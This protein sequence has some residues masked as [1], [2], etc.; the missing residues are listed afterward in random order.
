MGRKENKAEGTD[1][2]WWLVV[3]LFIALGM[4]R[5]PADKAARAETTQIEQQQKAEKKVAV[6]KEKSDKAF[7]EA[8]DKERKTKEEVERKAQD[9][10]NFKLS[11]QTI[12][13]KTLARNPE[14]YKGAK[15]T[16]TGKVLQVLESG[17]D[18]AM[19]ITI[20]QNMDKV[21]Y[22][23]YRKDSVE[24]RILEDDMVTFY[25]EFK[26]IKQYEA[27]M[28]NKVSVPEVY[29]RYITRKN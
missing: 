20:E 1:D 18:I 22:V 27:I 2:L 13:Y 21:F 8:A 3:V 10:Q 9:E 26:G 16:Y 19:R 23:N 29:A 12:D 17:N 4:T 7:K 28:G 6:D 15:V 24:S 11:A 5:T 25:G 14:Q